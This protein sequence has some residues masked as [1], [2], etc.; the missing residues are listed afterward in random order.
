M[1]VVMKIDLVGPKRR[2]LALGL[3][4]AAGYGGVALAVLSGWLASEYAARDVLVA[5]GAV[6]ALVALVSV[7][8]VR[9]TGEHVAL[10]QA[11]PRIRGDRRR[12]SAFADATYRDPALR[13]C[14]QAGFTNNLNDALAWGLV[15]LFLAAHGASASRSGWSPAST[16]RSGAAQ[17]WTGHW[18]DRVGRKPLIVAGM[19]VQAAALALLAA[20]GGARRQPSPRCARRRHGARLPDPDRRDLRCRQPGCAPAGGWHLSLLA[21]HGA[22]RRR[23]DRG[24]A[25]DAI[26]YSGAIALVAALTAASGLCGCA[27]HAGPRAPADAKQARAAGRS[28]RPS[29]ARARGARRGSAHRPRTE[30]AEGGPVSRRPV[31]DD[32]L[33]SMRLITMPQILDRPAAVVALR[34]PARRDA[35]RPRSPGPRRFCAGRRREDGWQRPSDFRIPSWPRYFARVDAGRGSPAVHADSGGGVAAR[36]PARAAAKSQAVPSDIAQDRLGLRGPFPTNGLAVRNRPH[37]REACLE[38]ARR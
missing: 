6:V 22:R 24:I 33:S 1:T 36:A 29:A 13:S 27:R 26:D 19:L 14:S 31:L 2:G 5:G 25:A 23:A 15:P 8:F 37:V 18:S 32:L 35:A 28:C 9:D 11:R 12:W 21:R 34:D 38:P 7:L 20:S 3:N 4:E 17:I 30:L 16:R 10:E